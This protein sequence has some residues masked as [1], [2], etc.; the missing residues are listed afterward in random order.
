MPKNPQPPKEWDNILDATKPG[1]TCIEMYYE[2]TGQEDC[3]YLNVFT[4]VSLAK[5]CYYF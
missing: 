5:T 3:L 2:K 1:K 4:P